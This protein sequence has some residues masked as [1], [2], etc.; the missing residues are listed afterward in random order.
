M[1]KQENQKNQIEPKEQ[2]NSKQVSIRM[3]V[4][5]CL[6]LV[7]CIFISA[8]GSRKNQKNQK[9][10]DT[11]NL[12]T[13]GFAFDT[14]YTISIFQG[15]TKDVLSQCI[16][17]CASFEMLLSS[18]APK[19]QLYQINELSESYRKILSSGELKGLKNGKIKLKPGRCAEIKAKL[20]DAH[21]KKSFAY[22]IME[23]GSL[24]VKADPVIIDLVK[25]GL[26]YYQLSKGGFDITI[27]AVSGLWSFDQRNSKLPSKTLIKQNLSL[28][29]AEYLS[30]SEEELRITNPGTRIDLGGIAK[31]YIA[32]QLK[33][34]L[35]KE[36]V[37]S[38]II[39][40]GGNVVCIGKRVDGSPFSIGI[41]QPFEKRN[42][43]VSTVNVEDKSIVSSG[44]YERYFMKKKK[45]YHHI[46]NPKTGYPVDNTLVG[47]TIMCDD[48]V[49]GDGLSTTCF[50]LGLK[51]AMK[52]VESMDG[53]EALFIT[54]S[55]QLIYTDG[56][57]DVIS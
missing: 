33:K 44:I 45:L 40:L 1:N 41:Q 5:V 7:V 25:K 14:T 15:G 57:K 24:T 20:T 28:V 50:S 13:T 49:D 43:V 19:S 10:Q 17:K 47:V 6:F 31:G 54:K 2:I 52:L 53:V 12:S 42:E 55:E 27:G 37:T 11:E 32:D 9:K 4:I 48:S 35:K 23:D 51:D 26:E 3:I 18:H 30:I 8:I 46:L 34:Y 39:N 21:G 29:K 36:G 22:D 56:M 38:G 16:A